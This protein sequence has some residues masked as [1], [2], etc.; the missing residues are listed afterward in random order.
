MLDKKK[1]LFFQRRYGI[2]KHE[3]MCERRNILESVES[4]WV[5][6]IDE[7]EVFRSLS[8]CDLWIR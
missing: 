7:E 3:S 6:K 2:L 4:L 8:S 5:V 1:R